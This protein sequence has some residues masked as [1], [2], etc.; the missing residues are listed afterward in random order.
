MFRDK[1]SSIKTSWFLSYFIIISLLL[2]SLLGIVFMLNTSIKSETIKN[3]EHIFTIITSD[4]T[5]V[6][7]NMDNMA[8]QLSTDRDF[9]SLFNELTLNPE[10]IFVIRKA[11]DYVDN[12]QITHPYAKNVCLYNVKSDTFLLD[13]GIFPG[14]Y[15]YK[16]YQIDGIDYISYQDWKQNFIKKYFHEL[17][18]TTNGEIVHLTA[19][20]DMQGLVESILILTMEDLTFS[21]NSL[22]E[23]NDINNV[24]ILNHLGQPVFAEKDNAVREGFV[25]QSIALEKSTNNYQFN[26]ETVRVHVSSPYANIQCVYAVAENDLFKI[27]RQLIAIISVGLFA[28]IAVV[29][30]VIFF[31]SKRH[32]KPIQNLLTT[33]SNYQDN[34]QLQSNEFAVIEACLDNLIKSERD[35]R[36]FREDYQKKM[37][38]EDFSTYLTSNRYH[39]SLSSLLDF[40]D[41]HFNHKSYFVGTIF[42]SNINEEIW[43]DESE[44]IEFSDER[45]MYLALT[46]IYS[47]SL[48]DDFPFLTIKT[49]TDKFCLLIGCD[50]EKTDEMT[51]IAEKRLNEACLAAND[52][53]GIDTFIYVS[54]SFAELEETHNMYERLQQV[55]PAVLPEKFKSQRV[56]FYHDLIDKKDFVS[57]FAFEELLSNVF[58]AKDAASAKNTL[59]QALESCQSIVSPLQ[60]SLFKNAL[61]NKL[62]TNTR[63]MNPA[64]IS[65]RLYTL[66]NQVPQAT[67][68]EQL[69]NILMDIIDD[70][71]QYKKPQNVIDQIKEYIDN[72]YSDTSL[73]INMLGEKF[74]LTPSYL[75]HL[76]KAESGQMLKE[77]IAIVRLSHA[78]SLLSTDMKLEEIAK[79]CGFIDAKLFIRT[80][81]KY[82]NTTPGQYR[83]DM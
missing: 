55:N 82:Y 41:I 74:S 78:K 52:Y 29:I 58:N 27:S 15:L 37:F 14:T 6:K 66:I 20:V 72:N 40:Y 75:S 24:I 53:A 5:Q 57:N 10:T 42:I 38:Q 81:K 49:G 26:N 25:N 12:M 62:A 59:V 79:N 17:Y 44:S 76:F 34:N 2:F 64:Q 33:L 31:Y 16:E 35:G 50:M 63:L 70:I 36:G 51:A 22:I 77:Y 9:S 28:I 61:L 39:R 7:E 69:A 73:N 68:V 18:A 46:N 13:G 23:G 1:K 48:G 60:F 45:L 19:L 11:F 32:Y 67:N 3:N 54:E 8:I 21:Y 65:E 83:K 4:I 71:F 30:W 43:S 80:F 47:E 56:V